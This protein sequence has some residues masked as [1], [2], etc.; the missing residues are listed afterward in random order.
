[1][2]RINLPIGVQKENPIFAAFLNGYDAS[3]NT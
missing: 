1:M 3:K 2:K